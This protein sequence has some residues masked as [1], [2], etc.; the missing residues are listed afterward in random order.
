[1]W[2]DGRSSGVVGM[3]W[4]AAVLVA[5]GGG[6]AQRSRYR[7][8]VG[9]ASSRYRGNASCCPWHRW[10]GDNGGDSVELI[11]W[12]R[13]GASSSRRGI[14][15]DEEHGARPWRGSRRQ[16]VAAAVSSA[17]RRQAR[18]QRRRTQGQ[19]RSSKLRARFGEQ[20]QHRARG[21]GRRYGRL[22]ETSVH[23]H[24]G[25]TSD[26]SHYA[27]VGGA[28]L[29]IVFQKTLKNMNPFSLGRRSSR[30]ENARSR[31]GFPAVVLGILV[32]WKSCAGVTTTCHKS[33]WAVPGG[34]SWSSQADA[35]PMDWAPFSP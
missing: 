8:L 14:S 20:R 30:L 11:V 18:G 27:L 17:L 2:L 25:P 13:L 6:Q 22:L 34:V 1:M 7:W 26:G 10:L 33:M 29:E 15:G 32:T 12:G 19:G 16:A 23:H 28:L 31:Q 5:G 3:I 21:L 9:T 35:R 4:W 24:V